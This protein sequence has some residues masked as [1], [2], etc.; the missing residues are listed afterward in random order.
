M[1]SQAISTSVMA[2]N[3]ESHHQSARMALDDVREAIRMGRVLEQQ[4]I[5][6]STA[7]RDRIDGEK[8]MKRR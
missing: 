6:E 3:T 8:A 2:R 5:V 7:W 4:G 1:L